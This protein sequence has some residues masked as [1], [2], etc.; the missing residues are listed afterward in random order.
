V[1]NHVGLQWDTHAELYG[2]VAT[3]LE[4]IQRRAFPIP[5]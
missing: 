2:R 4:P 1:A 5:I 3:G